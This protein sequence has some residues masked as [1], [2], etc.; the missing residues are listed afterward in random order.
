MNRALPNLSIIIILVITPHLAP[1]SDAQLNYEP[2]I[3]IIELL[4]PSPTIDT[5]I[6]MTI[7][8]DD[9]YGKIID[10]KILYSSDAIS[11]QEST[12]QYVSGEPSSPVL[13]GKIPPPSNEI[14]YYKIFVK[15]DAGFSVTK[16]YDPITLSL[17][18]SAP[19]IQTISPS[20]STPAEWDQV[21]VRSRILD[22]ESGIKTVTLSYWVDS[23]QDSI[24]ELPMAFVPN[25]SIS[26]RWDGIYQAFIPKQLEGTS[27]DLFVLATDYTG[28]TSRM[29]NHYDVK[30]IP[31]KYASFMINATGLDPKN[32]SVPIVV[33][34]RGQFPIEDDIVNIQVATS[35]E[36]Q[37]ESTIINQRNFNRIVEEEINRFQLQGRVNDYPFDR[38][39]LDLT[40]TVP[41]A[42]VEMNH[43]LVYNRTKISGQWFMY[44]TRSLTPD[45]NG[46]TKY[47]VNI[48]LERNASINAIRIPLVGILLLLGSIFALEN[49]RKNLNNRLLITLSAFAV[50]F[51]FSLSI[52]DAQPLTIGPTLGE[53]M[54]SFEIFVA[55]I[56][57]AITLTGYRASKSRWLLENRNPLTPRQI[58]FV[59]DWAA[60]GGFFSALYVIILIAFPGQ[61]WLIPTVLVCLG[62]GF[63]FRM[64]KERAVFLGRWVRRR[65]RRT[66]PS[67]F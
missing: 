39:H 20:P 27:V 22:S 66:R 67:L 44:D 64:P 7:S 33:S 11:W 46:G 65:F 61:F 16:E 59:F 42:D 28:H 38:Y 58:T 3:T 2:N 21:R 24:I 15:D 12:M 14:V 52:R 47:Q 32:P 45:G 55:I 34:G 9:V 31:E 25:E 13:M 30:A 63:V 60:F 23:N 19:V 51:T 57:V 50:I 4:P 56:C 1:R 17:D 53:V 5:E 35:R 49:N 29:D 41:F 37:F 62:Y 6:R 10:A 43:L 26:E 18:S 40:M 54:L 36:N 48:A 8:V